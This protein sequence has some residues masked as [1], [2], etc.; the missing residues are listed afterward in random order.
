MASVTITINTEVEERIV[1]DKYITNVIDNEREINKA[2][3]QG[4]R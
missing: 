4:L 2:N 1:N 3:L